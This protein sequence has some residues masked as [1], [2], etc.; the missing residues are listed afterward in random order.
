VHPAGQWRNGLDQK[1]GGE[2]ERRLQWKRRAC[3][4]LP[5]SMVVSSLCTRSRR[6]GGLLVSAK[7]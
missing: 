7:V 5:E 6:Q 2:V 3:Q 1:G 4:G